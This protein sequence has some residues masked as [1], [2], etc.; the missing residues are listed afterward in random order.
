MKLRFIRIG[1]PIVLGAF[2]LGFS[3]WHVTRSSLAK[4]DSKRTTIRFSHWQLEAGVRNAFDALARDYEALHPEIRIEQL[5]IPGRIYRQWTS[6]QLIGGS[7]PD[8]VEIGLGIGGEFFE[9]FRPITA[10]VNYPNP[11]NRGTALE[12]IP[13]RNTFN[14]GMVTS[15]SRDTFECIGASLFTGTIRFYCNM[16]LLRKVTG[17]D[18]LP[19]N[20]AELQA[21]C[22][23]VN[24]YSLR[25]G[26]K[27]EPIASSKLT[28]ALM[29]DDLMKAQTQK[30]ASRLNPSTGLPAGTYDFYLA[31][32]N[33]TWT[34]DDPAMQSVAQLW[35]EV[36]KLLTPG[37]AQI[38]NDQ[39][40]FRFVQEKAILL[41]GF[42]GQATSIFDQVSFPIGVFR[43]PQPDPA[44]PQFGAQMI[45]RSSEGSLR[46]WGPFGITNASRHPKLVLNFLHFLTSEE[47]SRKFTRI[48]RFLPTIVGVDPPA[49]MKPFMPDLH[50]YP[51]GPA[52][53][54]APDTKTL[55]LNTQHLLFGPKGSTERFLATLRELLGPAMR[56]DVE[57][58]TK[59]RLNSMR[60]TDTTIAGT[61]QLVAQS[62]DDPILMQKLQTL[63]ETQNE[64]EAAVHYNR[65]RLAQADRRTQAP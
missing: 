21:L 54:H 29:L 1:L 34:V 53:A 9:Y 46:T 6:S 10:E 3:I 59:T 8:L 52:L 42:S 61:Q 44:D 62:P 43:S 57:R 37:F 31:Y 2:A 13:W 4:H 49:D 27:I 51:A 18:L 45:A 11:Y 28:S 55:V 65:L 36:G 12:G 22:S 24:D 56:R 32:L 17:S 26:E 30:L 60:Q 25:T 40:H 64:M 58:S 19:A 35:L 15:F 33:G 7:A 38:E 48:S 23:A 20:F 16:D 50:G 39:A 47:A 5:P 14:D 41:M 63:L